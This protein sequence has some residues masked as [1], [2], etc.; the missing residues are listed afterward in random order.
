MS[1]GSMM[2]R[3]RSELARRMP[4]RL[5]HEYRMLR[6][7]RLA[8]F[9]PELAMLP[10]FLDRKAVAIDV[11][12][13]VGIYADLL[14][15]GSK[16]VLAFEPHPVCADY[17]R[18]LALGR[19]EVIQAALSS[20][21]GEASLRIPLEGSEDA[22]ALSSLSALN[23]FG[24]RSDQSIRLEAVKTTTLDRIG[25]RL[26][27]A[28]ERVAFVKIDV[29]GHELD[30]LSGGRQFLSAQRPVLLV[31]TEFRH[32]ADPEAV[33]QFASALGYEAYALV[34]GHTLEPVNAALLASRQSPELMRVGRHGGY[35]NNVFFIPRERWDQPSL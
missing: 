14:R 31:E 10:R 32:G 21:D 5:M 29:E 6:H 35:L 19:V 12:A 28:G 24:G 2:L 18:R 7:V 9:E 27:A 15:R 8:P 11:G 34:D 3:L 33:F 26:S 4:A 25:D 23:D 22:H 30:V 17:L 1:A 13:N 20:S 16:R